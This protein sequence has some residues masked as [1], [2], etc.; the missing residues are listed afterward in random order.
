MCL[1]TYQLVGIVTGSLLWILASILS[2]MDTPYALFPAVPGSSFQCFPWFAQCGQSYTIDSG[3][4]WFFRGLFILFFGPL[5]FE[6]WLIYISTMID[7]CVS[8]LGH[9]SDGILEPCSPLLVHGDRLR[10]KDRNT[11]QIRVT[12]TCYQACGLSSPLP[13]LP[14]KFLLSDPVALP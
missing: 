5:I 13:R 9:S 1:S 4:S 7:V 3:L 14:E 12:S 6:R 8:S 10:N 2:D 11:L